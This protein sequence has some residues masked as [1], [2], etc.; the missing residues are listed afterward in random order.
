MIHIIKE[1]LLAVESSNILAI[2]MYGSLCMGRIEFR[3][4][5]FPF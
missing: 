5:Q 3:T 4:R 2:G 1:R